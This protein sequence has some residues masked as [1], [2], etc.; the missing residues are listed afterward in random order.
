[1]VPLIGPKT[2]VNDMTDMDIIEKRL[3]DLESFYTDLPEIL[4]LRHERLETAARD[5]SARFDEINGRLN[6]MD[7]QMAM[8]T[9]DVRDMRSGVTRQLIEMD[10]RL[11]AQ[12][13]DIKAL[14]ADMA[15][16]KSTLKTDVSA[17]KT[18]VSALKTDVSALKA[19]IGEMKTGI[20]LI[21]ARLPQ[22]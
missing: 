15:A 1:M 22:S 3:R 13:A 12:Q 16:V 17:L 10:Q 21:L 8:L 4:N 14:Q 6:L 2:T 19:D 11:V 18:D 9:R 7:R 5:H 20:A